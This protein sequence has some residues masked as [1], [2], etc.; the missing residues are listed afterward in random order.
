MVRWQLN[1]VRNWAGQHD[2]VFAAMASITNKI[3]VNTNTKKV[4]IT[5]RTDQGQ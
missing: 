4:E 3:K 1:H 5:T 2:E